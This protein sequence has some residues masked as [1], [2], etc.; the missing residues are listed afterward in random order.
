MKLTTLAYLSRKLGKFDENP[1]KKRCSRLEQSRIEILVSLKR[2]VVTAP[3]VKVQA[4]VYIYG[5]AK[6]VVA[7][8]PLE[9]N[10][11]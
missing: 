8:R 7:F 5:I 3:L 9:F 1:Q 6:S 10:M 2:H 4:V 11:Q